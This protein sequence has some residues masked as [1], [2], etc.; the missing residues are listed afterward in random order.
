ML[1]LG[2]CYHNI[3]LAFAYVK[4]VSLSDF[5]VYS[6]LSEL[7]QIFSCLANR[8]AQLLA[9]KKVLVLLVRLL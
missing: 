6:A 7:L 1:R 9:V 2:F 8:V 4:Y 3:L 5:I